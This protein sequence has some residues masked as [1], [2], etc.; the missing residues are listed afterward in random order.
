MKKK[1]LNLNI[2]NYL[3]AIDKIFR[4]KEQKEIYMTYVMIVAAIFTF[5]YSLFWDSSLEG[6]QKT[7][8]SV[9]NFESKIDLDKAFIQL[10]PE[11]K[12]SL[13]K[14]E[15]NQ[16]NNDIIVN[17]DNNS[18][19]K[20]KIETISSLIY[21]ERTWGEYIDSISRN[22]QTYGVKIISFKNKY[23]LK[24]KSFGHILD[25]SIQSSG[26]FKNTMKFINSLEES[27]LVVDIHSLNIRAQNRLNTDL[28]ISVWGITY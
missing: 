11:S 3:H 4:E 26:N 12:I 8:V 28:N 20:S 13:L 6:F 27:D 16:I 1:F 15:L 10:N 24:D 9:D 2:E 17:K 7:K 19:I 21:D 14:K 5:S 18:Y 22:A 23:A 25:I